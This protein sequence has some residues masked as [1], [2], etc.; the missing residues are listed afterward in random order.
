M[1][2]STLTGVICP[3][4]VIYSH[5]HCVRYLRFACNLPYRASFVVEQHYLSTNFV[6]L[7][8]QFMKADVSRLKVR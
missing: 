8:Y 7:L 6:F 5:L 1:T 2:L 3:T 4:D